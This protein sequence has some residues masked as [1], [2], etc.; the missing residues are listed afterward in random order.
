[1]L[2]RNGREDQKD[3]FIKNDDTGQ[4]AIVTAV[5]SGIGDKLEKRLA[6]DC[7][8]LIFVARD[9]SRL[10]KV[11]I[12]LERINHTSVKTIVKYLMRPGSAEDICH[13]SRDEDIKMEN[14]VNSEGIESFGKFAE[15]E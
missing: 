5:S 9:Q 13:P 11:I 8:T 3:N 4:T 6:K 12:G 14:L 15:S 7:G 1:L 2:A 10:L